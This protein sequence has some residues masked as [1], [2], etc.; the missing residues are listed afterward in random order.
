MADPLSILASVAGVATAGTQLSLGLYKISNRLLNAPSEIAALAQELS[1]ISST[2]LHLE[3]LVKNSRIL[4]KTE[5]LTITQAILSRFTKLQKDLRDIIKD[6]AKSK[7]SKR[8]K[9]AF[10]HTKIQDVLLKINSLKA[11]L[12]LAVSIL[13]VA[14]EQHRIQK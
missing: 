3:E 8:L 12:M 10:Q 11:L 5:L 9:W 7:K 13:Q 6:I 2:T 4:A 1:L 14:T